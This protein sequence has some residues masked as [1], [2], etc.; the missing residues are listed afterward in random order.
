ML[1]Q[2]LI[3]RG[4][5]RL[6]KSI[7]ISSFEED[8]HDVNGQNAVSIALESTAYDCSLIQP[9]GLGKDTQLTSLCCYLFATTIVDL[10]HSEGF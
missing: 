1:F 2:Q 3:L 8:C 10:S 7:M 9:D 6:L 4:S 5:K